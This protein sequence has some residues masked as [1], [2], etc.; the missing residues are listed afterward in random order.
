MRIFSHR[1]L[2]SLGLGSATDVPL[3]PSSARFD[4][5]RIQSAPPA[6]P[7]RRSPS[8]PTGGET[9]PERVPGSEWSV[10]RPGL[11]TRLDQQKERVSRIPAVSPKDVEKFIRPEL[12]APDK[13]ARIVWHNVTFPYQ[14]ELVNAW[15]LAAC[16]VRDDSQLVDDFRQ[17][18]FWVVTRSVQEVIC[19][20]GAHVD[21]DGT[22][23][24]L[25][26]SRFGSSG[27]ARWATATGRL[28]TLLA[29][30]SRIRPPSDASPDRNF[31]SRR[32]SINLV[33]HFEMERALDLL[34][35]IAYCNFMVRVSNAF[36]M[37][38]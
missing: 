6:V 1:L 7:E 21:A 13:A 34:Y 16:C 3:P 4:W 31:A 11:P 8:L 38:L 26:R 29:A 2:L 5:D 33:R 35:H 28:S 14:P 17:T 19:R 32:R 25:P 15:F 27:F 22:C 12:Y 24:D 10:V 23:G 36:Q 30:R 20:N 18:I 9:V 37:P